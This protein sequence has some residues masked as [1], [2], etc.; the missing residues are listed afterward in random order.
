MQLLAT[1]SASL[2]PVCGCSA[3]GVLNLIIVLQILWYAKNTQE[4][5]KRQ[6]KKM[7]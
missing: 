7:E 6:A 5:A 1:K 2:T 3:G 4:Q